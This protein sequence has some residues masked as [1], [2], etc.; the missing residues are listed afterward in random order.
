MFHV[1]QFGMREIKETHCSYRKF[2]IGRADLY[3]LKALRYG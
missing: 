2:E 3:S 1:K